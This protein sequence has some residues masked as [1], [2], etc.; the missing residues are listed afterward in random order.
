MKKIIPL[1]SSMFLFSFMNCGG[2]EN[3]LSE[4]PQTDCTNFS[5]GWHFS[6]KNAPDSNVRMLTYPKYNI[7]YPICKDYVI[8]E[9][10]VDR[11]VRDSLGSFCEIK[12]LLNKRG[13]EALTEVMSNHYNEDL[14]FTIDNQIFQLTRINSRENNGELYFTD[15]C[16]NI[17]DI[18]CLI[19]KINCKIQHK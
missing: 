15:L 12:F 4:C 13:K 6:G 10:M 18:E 2:I 16:K 11:I 9:S 14:V 8:D 7:Q 3:D 5:F 17:P 19:A 1:I